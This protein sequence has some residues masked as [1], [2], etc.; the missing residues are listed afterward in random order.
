MPADPPDYPHLTLESAM[1]MPNDGSHYF[2]YEDLARALEPF[3][4]TQADMARD[5]KELTRDHVRRAD[6][7]AMRRE[8]NA[9]FNDAD[10]RFTRKEVSELRYQ[11][12]AGRLTAQDEAIKGVQGQLDEWQKTSGVTNQQWLLFAANAAM[13]LLMAIILYAML[14]R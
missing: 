5:I 2:T 6:L 3:M 7:E 11:E 13:T 12:L 8:M 9:W 1:P 4:R 14:R 10:D